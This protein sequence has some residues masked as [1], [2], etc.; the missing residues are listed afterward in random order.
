MS[1]PCINRGKQ[2]PTP[3]GAPLVPL[4]LSPS[5]ITRYARRVAGAESAT[6]RTHR[7]GVVLV[8][9]NA[10]A[11]SAAD[12]EQTRR[13]VSAVFLRMGYETVARGRDELLVL[14]PEPVEDGEVVPARVVEQ[15]AP[16]QGEFR[17]E[18]HGLRY[19]TAE[20]VAAESEPVHHTREQIEARFAE[21]DSFVLVLGP[22]DRAYDPETGDTFLGGVTIRYA[23]G[24]FPGSY[25]T[26]TITDDDPHVDDDPREQPAP[27]EWSESVGASA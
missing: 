1:Y 10:G 25:Y 18:E 13:R 8:T 15:E 20:E 6:S 11:E 19:V 27:V 7:D 14:A 23:R 24:S 22:D 16:L 17:R 21:V 9:L 4:S 26:A 3:N 5:A 12:A 2:S